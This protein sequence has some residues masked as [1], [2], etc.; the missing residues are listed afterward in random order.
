MP[1]TSSGQIDLNAIHVEAGGTTGT[2]CSMNDADIRGLISKGAAA[3]MG[4]NEWYGAS[5]SVTPQNISSFTSINGTAV[6]SIHA[7]YVHDNGDF[8]VHFRF[9]GQQFNARGISTNDGSSWST[10]TQL[11][12]SGSNQTFAPLALVN[13][14]DRSYLPFGSTG[15]VYTTQLGGKFSNMSWWYLP[16]TGRDLEIP[17]SQSY[18]RRTFHLG[19]DQNNKTGQIIGVGR[20]GTG[21]A[22]WQWNG[23]YTSTAIASSNVTS[24]PV[25]STGTGYIDNGHPWKKGS[26]VFMIGRGGTAAIQDPILSLYSSNSGSSYSAT[27]IRTLN[28]STEANQILR[29]GNSAVDEANDDY[30]LAVRVTLNTGNTIEQLYK[31]TASSAGTSWTQ[32]SSDMLDDCFGRTSSNDAGL[33]AAI[34]VYDGCFCLAWA[35]VAGT[36]GSYAS[37]TSAYSLRDGGWG[38]SGWVNHAV[39][40]YTGQNQGTTRRVAVNSNKKAMG[41]ENNTFRRFY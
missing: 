12:S 37:G 4:F 35:N 38:S 20:D 32:V 15:G 7:L 39:T 23:S 5:A 10:A 27:T 41:I 28:T 6:T 29:V 9:S 25:P 33:L 24:F 8:Q 26:N 3:Q 36:S 31:T 16:D 11:T 14:S 21:N 2:E 1:L 22:G 34:D 18:S 13:N 30:Y 19:R 17:N 40:L